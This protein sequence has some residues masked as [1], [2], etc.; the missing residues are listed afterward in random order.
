MG[1][2]RGLVVRVLAPEGL[3]VLVPAAVPLDSFALAT[4]VAVVAEVAG[5]AAA[6]EVVVA[7]GS[8]PGRHLAPRLR[9]RGSPAPAATG[10]VNSNTATSTDP[11]NPLRMAHSLN[12]CT[13]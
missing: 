7:G 3:V 9:A 6:V 13:P 2:C 5:H 4:V 11:T 8:H 1:S 12:P 10:R